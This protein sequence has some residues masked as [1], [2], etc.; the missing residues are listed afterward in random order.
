MLIVLSMLFTTNAYAAFDG[1]TR[2]FA[3]DPEITAVPDPDPPEEDAPAAESTPSPAQVMTG[4]GPIVG[5]QD[6]EPAEPPAGQTMTGPGPAALPGA[7]GMEATAY[8]TLTGFTER[9]SAGAIFVGA[10]VVDQRGLYRRLRP[11][12]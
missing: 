12:G 1:R 8:S 5:G 4:P 2:P 3:P 11:R 6:E 9:D 10:D 7:E